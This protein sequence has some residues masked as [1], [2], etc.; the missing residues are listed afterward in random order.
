MIPGSHKFRWSSFCS[1]LSTR[2]ANETRVF[3]NALVVRRAAQCFYV[4]IRMVKQIILIVLV[5]IGIG[6]LSL[7]TMLTPAFATVQA[8]DEGGN[9]ETGAPHQSGTTKGPILITCMV[10]RGCIERPV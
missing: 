6:T 3:F 10:G 9:R 5:V 2:A 1:I 7:G 4:T 8:H